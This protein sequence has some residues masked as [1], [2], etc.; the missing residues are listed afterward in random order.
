MLFRRS[1]NTYVAAVAADVLWPLFVT[2]F[3]GFDEGEDWD[4]F[5]Y[6]ERAA[7]E[8]VEEKC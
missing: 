4:R 5:R 1:K 8:D 3:G 2:S 6:G 7:A